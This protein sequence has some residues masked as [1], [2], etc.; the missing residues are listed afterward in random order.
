MRVKVENLAG[1][2]VQLPNVMDSSS[3]AV[4][5]F[6]SPECPLCKNYT[7]TLNQLV[8]DDP[9]L[10]VVAVYSGTD[11]DVQA[12][13]DFNTKYNNQF[14]TL[15]DKKYKLAKAF[16]ATVTPEVFLIDSSGNVIYSGL[17]DNWVIKLGGSH[18]REITAFY[19]TDAISSFRAGIT[20]AIQQTKAKGCLLYAN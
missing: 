8:Q 18:R 19:L 2:V 10:T 4:V 20:P 9:Q 1:E 17:I 5:V 13:T 6:C 11:Y 3:L 15:R 14:I 16:G 7:L 12:I